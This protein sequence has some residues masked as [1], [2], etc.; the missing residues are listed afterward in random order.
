MSNEEFNI[1]YYVFEEIVEYVEL[2]SQGEEK[3]KKW[4]NVKSLTNLAVLNGRLTKNQGE[5]LLKTYNR[6]II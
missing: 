6:E 1:P 3:V 4:E 5:F 2:T